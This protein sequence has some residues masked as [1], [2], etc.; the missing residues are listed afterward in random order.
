MTTVSAGDRFRAVDQAVGR[1]QQERQELAE[2]QARVGEL[3]ADRAE[4]GRLQ[5]LDRD[6]RYI[7]ADGLYRIAADKRFEPAVQANEDRRH[8]P[9]WKVSGAILGGGLAL[10]AAASVVPGVAPWVPGLL[11]G[12]GLFG[13]LVGP[14]N[15]R[16]LEDIHLR[17]RRVDEVLTGIL[18]REIARDEESLRTTR[19]RVVELE[20]SLAR[21]DEERVREEL[22]QAPQAA[23]IEERETTVEI[24]GVQLP[25]SRR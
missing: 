9:W 18:D 22:H 16:D 6:G 15:V 3:E 25:R 2:L 13:A 14:T 11:G 10:A 24:G 21:S 19:A 8:Q 12:I 4:L 7:Q 17:P 23:R 20:A 1:R 5:G